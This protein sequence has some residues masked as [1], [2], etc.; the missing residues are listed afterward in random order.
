MLGLIEDELISI[1]K[2]LQGGSRGWCECSTCARW[3]WLHRLVDRHPAI[4]RMYAIEGQQL[5]D[6]AAWDDAWEES[7]AT[8]PYR[9]GVWLEQFACRLT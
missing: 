3:Q 7:A 1:A 2:A 8:R 5:F 9:I 6:E 4:Q